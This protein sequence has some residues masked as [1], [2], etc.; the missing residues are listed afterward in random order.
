MRKSIN[1]FF[2]L[3]S[4]FLWRRPWQP[5]LVLLPGESQGRGS[6]VGCRLWGR[7]E[8]DTTEVTEQQQSL[9]LVLCYSSPKHW[10]QETFSWT[11]LLGSILPVIDFRFCDEIQVREANHFLCLKGTFCGIVYVYLPALMKINVGIL[12]H[13]VFNQILSSTRNLLASGSLGNQ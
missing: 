10:N 12:W 4:L 6:L 13:W 11:C 7:T 2:K 3:S 5:T 9:S 8:S 1:L